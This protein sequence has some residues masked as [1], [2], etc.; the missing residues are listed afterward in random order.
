MGLV[1]SL[2]S[3]ISNAINS[4]RK[5]PTVD[6]AAL[7]QTIANNKS[8]NQGLI[9]ALPDELKKQLADYQTQM[10]TAGATLQS[11]VQDQGQAYLD[12]VSK[13]YGPN[14][15]AAQAAM[16]AYKQQAYST[17]PGTLN[18]TKA[19]AAATGGLG[20]GGAAEAIGKAIQA[21]A[22]AVSQNAANVTAQQLQAGQQATQ[23]ALSTVNSMN[24]QMFNQLFGMSK[25]VATTIL[26]SGRQDLK[27][28]LSQLINS[29]NQA[30][31]QTLGL[32]G[33]Q[34]NQAYQ[35]AVTRNQQQAG[36]GSGFVNAGL[37]AVAD[38]YT[39]GLN[40]FTNHSGENGYDP[41]KDSQPAS[42]SQN[43]LPST[44]RINL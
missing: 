25:D 34:A 6:L 43:S 5:L 41:T 10:T 32:E 12:Q 28:Q 17:L 27:D 31:D 40:E 19:A 24:D 44:Y 4:G 35:N 42:G 1:D 15:P 37:N 7:Y 20:R 3:G 2:G 11:N 33:I 21:P 8:E 22:T 14:S 9:N 26:N 23:Q 39:G 29:N 30:T 13:L 16:A 36:I 38:Y 18:A